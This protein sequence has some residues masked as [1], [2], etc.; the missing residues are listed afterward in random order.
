V[1]A[2][3]GKVITL[4]SAILT[5]VGFAFFALLAFW[6]AFHPVRLISGGPPQPI[7]LSNEVGALT[8]FCMIGAVVL[9][10]LCIGFSSLFLKLRAQEVAETR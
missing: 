6:G 7:L 10:V 9:L 8:Y 1:I 5:L 3:I 4:L 2:K